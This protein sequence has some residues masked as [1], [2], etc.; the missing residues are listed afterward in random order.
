MEGVLN[1]V[2]KKQNDSLDQLPEAKKEL[3]Q[4]NE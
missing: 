3:M 1:S 2:D 4:G